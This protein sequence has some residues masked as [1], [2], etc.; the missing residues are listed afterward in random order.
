[1]LRTAAWLSARRDHAELMAA[2]DD[3]AAAQNH[4]LRSILGE[5]AETSFGRT[6]DF[7]SLQTAGEFR[8][9]VPVQEF[10]DLRPLIERQEATGEASLTVEKPVYY[11]RTSGTLGLPKDIP[12]T[13]SGLQRI[14]RHQR[15]SAYAFA[16]GSDVLSGKSLA[17]TGRAVEGHMPGGTPFGSASGLLYEQQSKLVRAR[18][19]LPTDVSAIDDYESRYF[20]IAAMGLAAADISALATANPSTLVKLQKLMNDRAEELIGCIASGAW[21]ETMAGALGDALP[22]RRDT[23]R[24]DA[25]RHVLS[26]R[27]A[28]LFADIWPGLNG[29]VTWTGGSC[30]YALK[31]LA[32]SLPAGCSTID[33]GYLASE[34]RGT[35]NID[36]GQNICVPTILDNYFEFVRRDD[37][38]NGGGDF[39]GVAQLEQGESYYVFV[40]T[41]DGLYRYD[42]ND[43]VRVTGFF[44][45]TPSLAFVQKGRGMTSITGEKLS[46]AQALAA[47][48]AALGE[49]SGTEGATGAGGAFFVLLADRDRSIYRLCI[50]VPANSADMPAD[51]ARRVDMDLARLNIEYA[52]K[53]ESG[54]LLPLELV[55]LA[56]GTGDAYRVAKVAAGQRDSQF[57]Y[58]HLQ[59]ADACDFDFN[60]HMADA[61]LR[62][63]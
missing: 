53:R 60:R 59:Y 41:P 17:I 18:Y 50:E 6:H 5:N 8:T 40:T 19:V 45:N 57:K 42:M 1:M 26:D 23:R 48:D 51:L 47:V 55:R 15:I 30:G 49:A 3:P 39:I 11:H 32:P 25:L 58:M 46:E 62:P 10:E 2:L 7:S 29:A 43:I 27:G 61:E 28:L 24:A 9:S 56:P 33:P 22:L 31:A 44:R 34:L 20:A 4:L 38:E 21:P 52:A 36:A 12:V 13:Q 37:W 54:R 35:V 63:A 16:R 14:K